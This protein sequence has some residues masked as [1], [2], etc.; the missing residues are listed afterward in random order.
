MKT[1]QRQMAI[2]KHLTWHTIADKNPFIACLLMHALKLHDYYKYI[3]R[4]KTEIKS[5]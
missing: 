5:F 3:F 2:L 1:W 4:K